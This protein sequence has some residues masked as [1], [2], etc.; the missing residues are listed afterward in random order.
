[1]QWRDDPCEIVELAIVAERQ[2]QGLGKQFVLWL[3]NEARRRPRSKP[4]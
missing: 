4:V 1:M 3:I 2:G